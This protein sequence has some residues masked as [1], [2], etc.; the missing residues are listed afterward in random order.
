MDQASLTDAGKGVSIFL[1]LIGGSSGST[2]G[3]A[4]TVTLVVLLNGGD[5]TNGKIAVPNLVG[6][7]YED[8]PEYPT[9]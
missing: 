6:Q 5:D 9:Q 8:L 3:G 2:A 1:M 4:K 7:V